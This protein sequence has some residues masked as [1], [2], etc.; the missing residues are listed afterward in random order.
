MGELV[1]LTVDCVDLKQREILVANGKGRK[2]RIVGMGDRLRGQLYRWVSQFRDVWG[3]ESPYLFTN[4]V[5]H[6]LTSRDVW[7]MV[8]NSGK[9]AGIEGVRCSPHSL[10]HTMASGLIADGLALSDLMV[11]LGHENIQTTAVYL[12]PHPKAVAERH[13]AKALGDKLKV[14]LS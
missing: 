14:K 3:E 12:H 5:G 10:R 6:Q 8:R 13:K 4:T 11:L 2:Q 9:K 1:A 7:I